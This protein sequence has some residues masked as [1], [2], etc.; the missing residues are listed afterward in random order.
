MKSIDLDAVKIRP[1]VTGDI[2]STLNIWWTDIPKKEMLASQMGGRFDLSLIAE[3]EGHLVG[4]IL[5]R[6]IYAGLPMTGVAVI[7]FIAIKPEYQ[8]LG[9]GSLLIDTLKKN[10]KAAGIETV[11]ALVPRDD[12][13]MMKYFKKAAF[14][15]SQ[16]INLDSPV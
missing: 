8:A 2:A 3:Y 10:C 15:R 14:S 7:F 6:L 16:I 4:F 1:M 5:A 12:A 9:I 13:R 11:R